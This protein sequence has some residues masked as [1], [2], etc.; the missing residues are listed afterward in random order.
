MGIKVSVGKVAM[1]FLHCTVAMS[2]E[3]KCKVK[4]GQN[5]II[6]EGENGDRRRKSE[7]HSKYLRFVRVGYVLIIL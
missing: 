4:S 7:E 2:N 3:V 5:K 1:A 6:G